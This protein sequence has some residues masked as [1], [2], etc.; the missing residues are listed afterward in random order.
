MAYSAKEKGC[1]DGCN[2]LKKWFEVLTLHYLLQEGAPSPRSV[3]RRYSSTVA[4]LAAAGGSSS[5]SRDLYSS[6]LDS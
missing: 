5:S 2:D 1:E 3:E 4:S 6:A